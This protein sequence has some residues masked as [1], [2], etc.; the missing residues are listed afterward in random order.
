VHLDHLEIATHVIYTHKMAWWGTIGTNI[1]SC[2]D[3]KDGEGEVLTSVQPDE[4]DGM[5]Y[6]PMDADLFPNL[7]TVIDV[8]DLSSIF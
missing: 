1:A 7:R 8:L 5:I 6:K 4:A 3:V 2:P